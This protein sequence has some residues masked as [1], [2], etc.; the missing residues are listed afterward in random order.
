M[1]KY[2][3]ILFFSFSFNVF[4]VKD[5][6]IEFEIDNKNLSEN[7]ID[8]IFDFVDMN[9]KIIFSISHLFS[10]QT[11][12]SSNPYG[13]IFSIHPEFLNIITKDCFLY[14][15]P[16]EDS[17]GTGLMVQDG[18][19]YAYPLSTKK[20][21]FLSQ[22]DIDTNRFF[23]LDE[24]QFSP[25]YTFS[26]DTILTQNRKTIQFTDFPDLKEGSPGIIG[27]YLLSGDYVCLNV[28][29]NPESD[30]DGIGFSALK[31]YKFNVARN[32]WRFLFASRLQDKDD[33]LYCISCQFNKFILCT[34]HGW[35]YKASEN[36]IKCIGT[37][38]DRISNQL[39]CALK[40]DGEMLYGHY[41]SGH[42][43][44]IIDDKQID[45]MEPPILNPVSENERE[46]MV[47][48]R[49]GG[50]IYV[51]IWPW[52]E[53]YKKDIN[54]LD[55]TPEM[56]CF[57]YPA[58]NKLE[59]PYANIVERHE[60]KFEYNEF[61]QRVYHMVPFD[62]YMFISTSGK[63]GNFRDLWNQAEGS[64]NIDLNEYGRIHSIKINGQYAFY[65]NKRDGVIKIKI[66]ILNSLNKIN[67]YVDDIII[68][69]LK[70]CSIKIPVRY[71]YKM[72]DHINTISVNY[73][74]H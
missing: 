54:T 28:V 10:W 43:H 20:N 70:N 48:V 37:N 33:F 62:E 40:L 49:Y 42:I 27:K 17:T 74:E 60:W 65:V 55:W 66:E 5:I 71:S 9:N 30:P 8:N 11:T 35:I 72:F 58:F 68:K 1:F 18:R 59:A 21:V 2:L 16:F 7:K 25:Y 3:Y 52:G 44:K 51:G 26:N 57:T 23:N 63:S 45:T 12:R 64:G 46:L 22:Y 39:Y 6:V 41:P 4:A 38:Y 73:S 32:K 29:V 67:F 47:M 34:S 14:N 61:G 53:V 50:S 69:T 36:G 24:I 15:N 56:R 19:L 31:I 13:I